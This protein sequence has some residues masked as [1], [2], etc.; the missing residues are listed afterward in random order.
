MTFKLGE[1]KSAKK[2]MRMPLRFLLRDAIVRFVIRRYL[3]V[4]WWMAGG[5]WYSID[6]DFCVGDECGIELHAAGVFLGTLFYGYDMPFT[7]SFVMFID[8]EGNEFDLTPG[9]TMRERSEILRNVLQDEK[10][11]HVLDARD[12]GSVS[13]I[14]EG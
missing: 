6:D 14:G 13:D 4:L 2:P 7:E 12:P 10:D 3:V 5:L 11:S 8:R 1:K 9:K